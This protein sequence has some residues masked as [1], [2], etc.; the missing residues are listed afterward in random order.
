MRGSRPAVAAWKAAVSVLKH[1][2]YRAPGIRAAF[3]AAAVRPGPGFGPAPNW[4]VVSTTMRPSSGPVA[5]S[6]SG[7]ASQGTASTTTSAAA[8]AW[9]GSATRAPMSSASTWSR[10]ASRANARVMSC[11]AAASRRAMPP[12]IS[13]APMTAILIVPP[14]RRGR[15]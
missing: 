6:A 7:T 10:C 3:M 9:A 8:T 1:F 4:F 12:P 14:S 11:P 13:P 2:T 5:R 15:R